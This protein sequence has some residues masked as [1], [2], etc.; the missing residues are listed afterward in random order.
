MF[1][2]EPAEVLFRPCQADS[3]ISFLRTDV[4]EPVRISASPQNI[5]ERGRRTTLRKG[6]VNIET[7]EHCLAAVWALGIDNLSIE[8]DGPELPAPDCSSN[9]YFRLLND[10]GLLEQQAEKKLF[11]IKEPVM[12][13]AAG[14]SIYALPAPEDGLS[15]RTFL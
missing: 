4:D 10:A 9:K 11:T 2:G 14:A 8:I 15:I 13:S 7:V 1:G 12:V 3:G 5:A 6:E